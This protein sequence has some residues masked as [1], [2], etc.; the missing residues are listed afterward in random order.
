MKKL[1]AEKLSPAAEQMKVHLS[2]SSLSLAL[3][4]AHIASEKPSILAPL[5]EL[6]IKEIAPWSQRASHVLIK[7]NDAYPHLIH[8]Y[9]KQ[10]V[11][12]LPHL[13]SE[14]ARRNLLKIISES[15][16]SFTEKEKSVL[17]GCCFDFLEGENEVGVKMFSIEILYQLSKEYTEIRKELTDLLESQMSGASPGFISRATK[18][19]HH[20][21][22][23]MH[24]S[25]R[26]K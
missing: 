21:S 5:L 9:L 25:A 26:R 24:H 8:P 4:T 18:T 3:L 16:Y 11:K 22:Q 6:S 10:M 17:L 19:L 1:L 14:G 13:K 12:N 23:D 20:I 7:C 2:E 15:N